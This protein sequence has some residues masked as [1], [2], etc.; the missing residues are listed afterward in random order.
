MTD[1]Y[2]LFEWCYWEETVKCKYHGVYILS[3][4][5]LK[6]SSDNY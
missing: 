6:P 4:L 3:E 1:S 5:N 2:R